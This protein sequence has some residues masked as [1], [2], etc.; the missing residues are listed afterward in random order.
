[1]AAQDN[2]S[3]SDNKNQSPTTYLNKN[4]RLFNCPLEIKEVLL[5]YHKP[6]MNLYCSIYLSLVLVIRNILLC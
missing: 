6:R 4:I 5:M 2:V 3:V 1:M